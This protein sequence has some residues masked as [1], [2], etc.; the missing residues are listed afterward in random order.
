MAERQSVRIIGGKWR[1]RKLTIS[2]ASQVR[3]SPDRV[4]ETVF[5]WLAPYIFEAR[6]LDLFAGSGALG[7]EALSRGAKSALMM[8]HD[9]IVI[10][11]L[12]REK[13]KLSAE[14]A[15]TVCHRFPEPLKTQPQPFNIVFL[16]PPFHQNLIAQAFEWLH[17]QQML[18]SDALIYVEA[19]SSLTPLP[20]LHH[21][22]V[23]REK[24]AGQVGYYLLGAER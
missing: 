21:W 15:S 22:Q 13:E 4:R 3:P 17:N 14:A 19:E 2:A 10:Q 20:I 5:N 12:N 16:D 18:A 8:D 6:V 24:K 9:Q 7:F 1:G 11:Q 23:L